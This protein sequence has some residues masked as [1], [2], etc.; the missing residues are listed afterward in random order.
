MIGLQIHDIFQYVQSTDPSGDVD[1]PGAKTNW[2]DTTTASSPIWKRRNDA[3][4]AWITM[5]DASTPGLTTEQ[6][7][8]I[9]GALVIDTLSVN[10]TYNDGTNELTFDI[11]DEYIQDLVGLMATD[12]SS[13]D[14]TYNDGAGTLSF[15]II[16]E[17][18]QDQVAAMFTG[19]SHT[20]L[21]ATY[22]DAGGVIDL[23]ASAG[24][25]LV[26][27]KDSV[28]VA[29]AAALPANTRTGNVL[30]ASANG[31]L[32]AVDGVTLVLN[33]RLLVK[34]EAAGENN[35]I[36]YVSAVGDGSNPFTLTRTTDADVSSEVTS[37]M[38][39]VATEGTTNGDK[40]WILT[41]N[42]T[43]T[44]N[45]TALVFS[46]VTGGSSPLTTKG[47]IYT[48]DATADDRLA[49]GSNGQVLVA[50]SS[51]DTGLK[52]Q[53]EFYGLELLITDGL[54]SPLTAGVKGW[55][56]VPHT[57]TIV[58]SFA[59]PE[60]SGSV[61]VDLWKCTYADFDAFSTHPVNGDSITASAPIS[62]SSGTKASDTTLT[63]WTTTV[64]KGD[65]IAF[66]VDSAT[67]IE[68]VLVG[69]I[70]KRGLS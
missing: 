15:D 20:N 2:L 63:G 54:G 34:N 8:D 28:R 48:R 11:V 43:V 45:T 69:I 65:I 68:T 27:F 67:T 37:G 7:Q 32:A 29:T 40:I 47:D 12:T 4:N 59:L 56:R 19:G 35:G 33:D 58:E 41:T 38:A 1:F 64:T 16:L 60:Q 66:N 25:S 46:G 18:L 3:D 49:V 44:L 62:I 17:Y 10:V 61:V 22:Q 24:T 39:V 13:I 31:A 21:T 5:V 51:Q 36:Y 6:V 14:A 23:A 52:W 42:D 57:G 26:D 55:L 50:D 53:D 9:V 30:T 70:I